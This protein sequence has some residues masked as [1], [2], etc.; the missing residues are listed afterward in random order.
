MNKPKLLIVD[1]DAEY[2]ETLEKIFMES[3]EFTVQPSVQNGEDALK[4]VAKGDIEVVLLNIVIPK[5]GLEVLGQIKKMDIPQHPKIFI[6]SAINT[7]SV[8]EMTLSSGAQ[9]YF[10]RPI[11]PLVMVKRIRDFMGMDQ[12][13]AFGACDC[14][15][16]KKDEK[17]DKM[18]EDIITSLIL[19]LNI[20]ASI[21]G[22]HYIR[23]SIQLY[24]A[25]NNQVGMTTRIYPEVAKAFDSTPSR[26]ERAI[27][28]AIS[29]AWNRSSVEVLNDMFGYT[30]NKDKGM[31]TNSEFIAMLAVKART[32][33]KKIV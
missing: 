18:L 15:T 25:N 6:H 24:I 8:I 16:L 4:R 23:R 17:R 3:H 28:H 31:S 19:Q 26:V 33:M 2:C 9:Y 32:E 12:N 14:G 30:V 5:D 21:K 7:D 1:S 11:D 20:P 29:V 10:Q 22:Y 27:R 13:P